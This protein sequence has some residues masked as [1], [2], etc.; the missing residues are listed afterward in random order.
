MRRLVEL[1]YETVG[2]ME[3]RK[4]ASWYLKDVRG[5]DKSKKAL[6]Q[7]E[8][9]QQIIDIL[10]EFQKEINAKDNEKVEQEA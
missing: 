9:G 6:N 1:K 4:H 3:I 5:N 8:T 7:A 10:Q 2:T